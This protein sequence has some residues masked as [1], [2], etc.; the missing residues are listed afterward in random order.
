MITRCVLDKNEGIP[1]GRGGGTGLAGGILRPRE[2]RG[3]EEL[4]GG[5]A[6]V[7]EDGAGLTAGAFAPIGIVLFWAKRSGGRLSSPGGFIPVAD[8]LISG[9]GSSETGVGGAGQLAVVALGALGFLF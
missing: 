6:E 7:E 9:V 3:G 5:G 2:A 4:I 8:G 1:G